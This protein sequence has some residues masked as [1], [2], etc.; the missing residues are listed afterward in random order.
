MILKLNPSMMPVLI[1]GV[2]AQEGTPARTSKLIKEQVIPE[3]ESL[4]G[5]ASVTAIGSI[6]ETVEVTVNAKK[7]EELSDEVT[8]ELD[9]KFDEAS[10]AL[11]DAK[12]QA[13]NGKAQLEAG[14]GQAAKQL[15]QAEAEMSKKAEELK[16]AQLE[17]TEKMA[18]LNVGGGTDA[19]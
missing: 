19:A 10:A 2:S 16:Q 1:A 17:I 5:V 15:G 3:I 9:R 11:A 7:V 18:E 8:A 4:E 13:E 14:Q 6:E 12:A